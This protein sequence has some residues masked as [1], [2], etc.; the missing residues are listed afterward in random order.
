VSWRGRSEKF[1]YESHES[2][3]YS[4]LLHVTCNGISQISHATTHQLRGVRVTL[5]WLIME[6][7]RNSI[8]N[9]MRVILTP[10][11][12]CGVAWEIWEIP[13]RVTW[14]W[15]LPPFTGVVWRGISYDTP[16]T[17]HWIWPYVMTTGE[18]WRGRSEKSHYGSHESDPMS[19]LLTSNENSIWE[20]MKVLLLSKISAI[21]VYHQ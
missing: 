4:P 11:Y 12:W 3:P 16:I 17:S 13:L 18:S 5:M 9:H 15:P 8:T 1:H 2:D 19:W 10:L 6:F 20:T 7:L 21:S 14:E